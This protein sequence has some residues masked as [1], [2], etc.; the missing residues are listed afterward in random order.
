MPRRGENIR[1]RKDGRWEARYIASHAPEG[2]AIY[3]SV[4]GHSY[5]EVK[6]KQKNV[7]IEPPKKPEIL[8]SLH[9][10]PVQ[11]LCTEWL[12]DVIGLKSSSYGTYSELIEN[13]IASYFQGMGVEQLT[14]D[15]V[16]GFIRVKCERGRIDEKGGLSDK[17]VRDMA[18]LLIQIISFGQRKGYIKGFD[19]ANVQLPKVKNEQVPVLSSADYDR[20]VTYSLTNIDCDTVGVL[21]ALFTGIRLGE[22]C[23]LIWLDI[24]FETGVLHITKT[25]Q[26]IKNTDRNA[27][28]KT[29]I[30]I[31]KPKSA[32]SVRSI[33][34][35]AF[36]LEILKQLKDDQSPDCYILSGT[37]KYVE[38]RLF[39]KRY[40]KILVL[41]LIAYINVHVLRHSFATKAIENGFDVKNLSEIL[42]HSSVR[43]TL[44]RYVRGSVE[45]KR[46][47]ME[48][49][50]VRY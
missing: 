28:T 38:P 46:Q 26:R 3:Q 1:K 47:Y 5:A 48:K 16:N 25:L 33:P 15:T 36:L 4:Y 20:L 10:I 21:L 13:H 11:M 14:C 35:P 17:Y 34:I 40:K 24:D 39:Q 31:G 18:V 8:F 41:A 23:A 12:D 45:Q 6:E 9:G 44:D 50:A 19:Y 32:C 29:K 22:L 27:K 7:L 37:L 2:K 42:G 30:T 43:F 49:M